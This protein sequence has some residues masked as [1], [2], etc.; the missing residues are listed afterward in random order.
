MEG[1]TTFPNLDSLFYIT[2]NMVYADPQPTQYLQYINNP[3]CCQ[4]NLKFK[5][6]SS[7]DMNT[8][9]NFYVQQSGQLKPFIFTSPRDGQQYI[10]RFVNKSMSRT[11]FAYLLESTGLNLV[12]VIGE[13]ELNNGRRDVNGIICV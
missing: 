8:L 7:T 3:L 9:W 4:F 13:D 1:L 10:V 5:M 2:E 12:E 11:L 6:L